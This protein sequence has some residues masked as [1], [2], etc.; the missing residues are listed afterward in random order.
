[1]LSYVATSF[2]VVIATIKDGKLHFCVTYRIIN[3]KM[4][5]DKF[6]LPKIEEIFDEFSSWGFF[7]SL[8]LF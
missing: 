3:L 4:K 6:P 5:A 1:M 8:D 2:P 7:T